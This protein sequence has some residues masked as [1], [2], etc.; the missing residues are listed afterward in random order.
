MHHHHHHHLFL[1]NLLPRFPI[2][3]PWRLDE[4]WDLVSGLHC[5][6]LSKENKDESAAEISL[7][8]ML[9]HDTTLMLSS[10]SQCRITDSNPLVVSTEHPSKDSNLTLLQEKKKRT[11]K[12]LS[13]QGLCITQCSNQSKSFSEMRMQSGLKESKQQNVLSSL[14]P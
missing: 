6:S 1:K 14:L 7:S 13:F 11:I 4:R 2:P 10:S 12:C 3:V 9:L 8:F 5:N